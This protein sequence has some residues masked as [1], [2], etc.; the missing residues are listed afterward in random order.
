MRV[1]PAATTATGTAAG[2]AI[3]LSLLLAQHA[4]A[5]DSSASASASTV[6]SCSTTKGPIKI[7]V[8]P[9]WAPL[10]ATH[11]LELVRDDFYT[12]IAFF[13]CVKGFLTQ[14]GLTTNPEKKHLHYKTIP[15]DPPSGH[16]ISQYVVSYAGSGPNSRNTQLFFAF[17]DLDFLGKAPWEVPFGRV[18]EGFDVLE[19]L[20]KGYGK[21]KV[22]CTMQRFCC[23][24]TFASRILITNI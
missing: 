11:F 15:D 23:C 17:E 24:C 7:E 14:F 20:Y 9:Q 4:A 10:G 18:I 12:D 21:L 16:P 19:N 3:W 2:T 13:R 22:Y 8:I 1:V 6:V 5:A